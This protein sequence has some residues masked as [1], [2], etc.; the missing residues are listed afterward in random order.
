MELKLKEDVKLTNLMSKKRIITS[1]L[2]MVGE[3][4][5]YT[6]TDIKLY[7]ML[8]MMNEMVEGNVLLF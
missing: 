5:N 8:S 6:E 4:D 3:Q 1:T 7:L 2:E